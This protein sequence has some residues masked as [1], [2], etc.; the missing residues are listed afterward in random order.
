[1][2]EEKTMFVVQFDWEFGV[3][4]TPAEVAAVFTRYERAEG[5]CISSVELLPDGG[6]VRAWEQ[7]GHAYLPNTWV[8]YEVTR[9]GD[10]V[11]STPREVVEYHSLEGW[12]VRTQVILG[13]MACVTEEKARANRTV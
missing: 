12:G 3:V 1:M 9:A 8:E 13:G 7:A 10:V 5:P 6:T 11:T 4:A 2:G